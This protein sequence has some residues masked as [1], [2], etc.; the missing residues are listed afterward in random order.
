L[1]AH[2]RL[3]IFEKRV[4]RR[5]FGPKRTRQ[6]ESGESYMKRSLTL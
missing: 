3:R 5:I 6:Q 4:L 1:V 2:I